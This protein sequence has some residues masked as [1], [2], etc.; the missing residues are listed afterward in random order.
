[1][2]N[3]KPVL[4]DLTR[5]IDD[6]GSLVELARK[7]WGLMP[8]EINQV[9]TVHDRAAGVRRCWHKHEYL[10]DLFTIVHGSAIFAMVGEGGYAKRFVLSDEKP[11]LLVVPPTF[12]HGWC[13]LE[14]DTL[15][16]SMASHEYNKSEPDEERVSPDSFMELFD[17]RDPFTIWAK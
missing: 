2:D 6:R 3:H 16:V 11:Q 1:M 17:N 12:Y 7:S 14:D 5:H 13:S 9:Y 4:I 8:H 15:L 10:W